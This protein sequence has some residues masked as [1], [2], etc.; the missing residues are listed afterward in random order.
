MAEHVEGGGSG[1][2]REELGDGVRQLREDVSRDKLESRLDDAVAERPLVRHLLDMRVVVKAL[3]IAAVLT[4]I[5]SV[6][7]SPKLGALV[8]VVSFGAAWFI[9]ATR[10]YDR[11]RPTTPADADEDDEADS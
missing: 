9:T 10:Q 1:G 6:L 7:L 2:L 5:V 4:L 11:R 8:L 3:L